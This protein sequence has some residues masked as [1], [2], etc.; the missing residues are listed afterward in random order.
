MSYS[1]FSLCILVQIAV[2]WSAITTYAA[3]LWIQR[4]RACESVC[5]RSLLFHSSSKTGTLMVLLSCK[6]KTVESGM[7]W[8][9]FSFRITCVSSLI[10][11]SVMTLSVI[12][13]SDIC[14]LNIKTKDK[15][16]LQKQTPWWHKWSKSFP[17]EWPVQNFAFLLV[18]F[19]LCEPGDFGVH[20]ST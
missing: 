15:T 17:W 11:V 19:S 10:L 14:S 1:A 12:M 3:R 7:N 13:A 6:C 2:S 16:K 8:K 18:C 9:H 20:F 4:I 5:W